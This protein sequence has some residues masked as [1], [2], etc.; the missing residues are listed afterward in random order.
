MALV[1][2]YKYFCACGQFLFSNAEIRST[3][4]LFTRF[5]VFIENRADLNIRIFGSNGVRCGSCLRSL[6]GMVY[7]TYW[8]QPDQIRFCGHLLYRR[9]VVIAIQSVI[10]ENGAL[11]SGEFHNILINGKLDLVRGIVGPLIYCD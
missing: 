5:Y 9:K 3:S 2:F 4:S 1:H 8:N 6:G 10:D 7:L 11:V